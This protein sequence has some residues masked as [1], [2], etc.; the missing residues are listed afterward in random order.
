MQLKTYSSVE[1]FQI[2]ANSAL[3]NTDINVLLLTALYA[4]KDATLPLVLATDRSGI[5]T[6]LLTR[7]QH[8]WCLGGQSPE[9]SISIARHLHQ[10]SLHTNWLHGE[11]SLTSNFINEWNRLSGKSIALAYSFEHMALAKEKLTLPSKPQ[12]VFAW[13]GEQDIPRV[14]AASVNFYKESLNAEHTIESQI[15]RLRPVV[16]EQRI[17]VWKDQAGQIVSQM[18][19]MHGPPNEV[20]MA[21]L[22]TPPTMRGHGYAK[23]LVAT[24][25][26]VLSNRGYRLTLFANPKKQHVV[27][28]Y[29]GLGYETK[30][31]IDRYDNL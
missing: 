4:A 16:T 19:F 31:R 3:E 2:G 22:Y 9:A 6:C 18:E 1:A 11:A 15:D 23:A 24:F 30:T 13:A 7:P 25:S 17:C 26:Q 29:K 21:Y 28:L 20:R 5:Q 14:A 27:N 10:E 8:G 12:G